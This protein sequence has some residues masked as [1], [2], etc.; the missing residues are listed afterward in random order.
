MGWSRGLLKTLEFRFVKV[1]WSRIW[2]VW[3]CL[4]GLC[5]LCCWGFGTLWGGRWSGWRAG[6][7]FLGKGC[8]WGRRVW[9]WNFRRG[10]TPAGWGGSGAR[11]ESLFCFY[12]LRGS[13]LLCA[14]R[15]F[16]GWLSRFRLGLAFLDAPVGKM[17]KFWFCSWK[18]WGFVSRSKCEGFQGKIYPWSHWCSRPG[19]LGS[20]GPHTLRYRGF[21][22]YLCWGIEGAGRILGP[23]IDPQSLFRGFPAGNKR[24]RHYQPFCSIVIDLPW[25][26]L[27]PRVRGV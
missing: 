16:R 22:Y 4:L 26:F 1:F 3:G 12:A 17:G 2:R 13:W 24:M 9:L 5:G 14:P 21:C 18:G 20:G 23:G 10:I 6:R 15:R 7:G 19:R 25:R 11:L 27:G 8:F